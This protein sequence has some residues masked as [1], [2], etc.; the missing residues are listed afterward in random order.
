MIIEAHLKDGERFSFVTY[1]QGLGRVKVDLSVNCNEGIFQHKEWGKETVEEDFVNLIGK[2]T[3]S[4]SMK[5]WSLAGLM[6]DYGL[7]YCLYD[8]LTFAYEL[9]L[10]MANTTDRKAPFY[11]ML[12]D[13]IAR[14]IYGCGIKDVNTSVESE[15]GDTMY[16]VDYF[17]LEN[18]EHVSPDDMDNEVQKFL[19]TISG[20][21][22][23]NIVSELANIYI[24]LTDVE[25]CF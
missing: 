23:R 14:K 2:T 10:Q 15:E 17:S 8:G 6:F 5:N 25:L 24:N 1:T 13:F 21:D 18:G 22:Q 9:G 16:L 19:N 3:M 11:T 12:A 4:A 20:E 7:N